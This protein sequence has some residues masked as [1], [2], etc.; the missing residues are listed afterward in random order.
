MAT[1]VHEPPRVEPLR[2]GIPG[3]GNGGWRNLTPTGGSLRAVRDPDSSPTSR[4]GIWVGL[5][6]ITMTFAAFTSALVVRQGGAADWKH[7]TLPPILWLNTAFLF[8]SSITLEVARR[9]V[10]VFARG[11]NPAKIVPLSW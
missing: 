2:P 9:R 1:T 11:L 4:T 7:L 3:S 10:A 6:G 5:A 8:A